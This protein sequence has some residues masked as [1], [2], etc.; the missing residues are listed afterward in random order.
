MTE[1]FL[2]C[3]LCRQSAFPYNGD[4]M[5][6]SATKTRFA[7]SP[8]GL[9]H[10]GNAR[11][12][13]FNALLALRHGGV[14]LLRIEDT[15]LERSR[16]EY[17]RALIGDM[18]W[19][20]LDWQ[21]GEDAGGPHAPYRQSE[22]GA[23][24]QR[25]Y[26]QLTQAGRV[27]PCFC[28]ET[29]LKLS[30]KAQLN[31]GQPPRY[32]GRCSHL[33]SD[34]VAAKVAAGQLPTLRFRVPKGEE[35][36]FD[37]LVRGSQRFRSD[38]IGDFI[39]RRADG[40]PA[41]FFT[42]A[43]DD[44]LMGVSQVVRGEDHLTNTPRQILLLKALDLPV[45]GYAHISMITGSDGS[46]LSKRHGSLGIAELREAGFLPGAVINHLAR[47]GHYFGHDDYQG[48]AGL[49][50]EFE[51]ARL[52]K[53]PAAHDDGRLLYW[54][55]E[56]IGHASVDELWEW[57][58]TEVRAR[59]PAAEAE[60]F[61]AAVR[62]NV[63]MRSDALRWAERIYAEQLELEQPCLDIVQGA[64]D[65]FFR[66]ALEALALHGP[67]W[68]P[69]AD[70]VKQRTGIKGKGLFMPL[71]VA[72][73]GE[74]HGPEMARVLPLVGLERARRRLEVWVNNE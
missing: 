48:L 59:V 74:A 2:W 67:H 42:N 36:L 25:Y 64:G 49:A 56:A 60:P 43:V 46:P 55:K 3:H 47:L 6:P 9:I 68:S 21:E 19:L 65:E 31:A 22:R 44:A 17:V 29:E 41:F 51:P 66:H 72:L 27:Y 10:L 13:L 34:E 7:P 30:R 16:D 54:Q 8:T 63:V 1:I 57:V 18:R 4:P 73:T 35:I 12:A 23:I 37:D 69:L 20:G 32:S 14:F 58:G 38:D 5:Q 70:E 45:P 71:R 28:S 52:A 53:A 39:I 11:T 33:S 62:D 26:D 61:I 50:A 40:T 15:D 24:Y